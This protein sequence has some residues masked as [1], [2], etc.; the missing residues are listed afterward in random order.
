[1]AT[2]LGRHSYMSP[3][4]L[5][6]FQTSGWA[7]VPIAPVECRRNPFLITAFRV[8]EPHFAHLVSLKKRDPRGN[9]LVLRPIDF[10]LK[11]PCKRPR[12]SQSEC[13]LRTTPGVVGDTLGEGRGMGKNTVTSWRLTVALVR[14]SKPS[15]RMGCPLACARRGGG[16]HSGPTGQ[17]S[18]RKL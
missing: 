12:G 16:G 18:I 8:I 17:P 10:V 2:G 4:G 13:H 15:D 6:S 9:P 5:S 14:A 11:R 7:G 3:N 1:M